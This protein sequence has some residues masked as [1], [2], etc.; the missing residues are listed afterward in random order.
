MFLKNVQEDDVVI[1]FNLVQQSNNQIIDED[2]F[3]KMVAERAYCKSEK[4]GF[5]EGYEMDDWLEAEREIANRCFYWFQ[6]Y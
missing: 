2:R 4:R 1:D 5:V 6:E 3:K